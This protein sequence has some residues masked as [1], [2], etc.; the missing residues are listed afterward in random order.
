MTP[1][2]LEKGTAYEKVTFIV[3]SNLIIITADGLSKK[4]G[5]SG[6]NRR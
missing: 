2:H 4:G 3:V 1:S 5:G 6:N